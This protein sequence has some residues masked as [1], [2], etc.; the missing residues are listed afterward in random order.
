MGNT[1]VGVA[2]AACEMV[3]VVPEGGGFVMYVRAGMLV[4][5]MGCPTASP[6]MLDTPV[7]V[8]LPLVMT[9]VGVA[10]ALAVIAVIAEPK[11]IP[12]PLMMSPTT[13][14]VL[15]STA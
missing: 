8:V 9:P 3:I 4:P 7:M 12:V 14:D 1:A 6:T 2:W 11:G 5:V 15:A 13:A 10:F